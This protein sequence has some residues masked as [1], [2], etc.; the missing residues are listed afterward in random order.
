[1]KF[2]EKL[3]IDDFLKTVANFHKS[4]EYAKDAMDEYL[5]NPSD[6]EEN[7][8][9]NFARMA[10][11]KAFEITVEAS[12]KMMQRWVK[13]NADNKIHEKPKRELFRTAHH[14]GLIS[15]P[16]AWWGFYEARN[17][18]AHTYHEEVAK[19]VYELANSFKAYLQD[20][21]KRLEE[22]I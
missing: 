5:D 21:T 6:E 7:F 12:W 11:I 20:F 3:N 18:T 10:V 4:L 1:M 22:R 13:I 9:I 15:D 16:V 17:K 2:E 19:E 8:M 14:S